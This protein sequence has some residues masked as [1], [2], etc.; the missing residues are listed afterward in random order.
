MT[1][2]VL[3]DVWEL[4]MDFVFPGWK[5]VGC[6]A[7]DGTGCPCLRGRD[8]QSIELGCECGCPE[9]GRKPE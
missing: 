4:E 2:L 9:C 5:D 7:C 3:D 8:W 6:D 1:D